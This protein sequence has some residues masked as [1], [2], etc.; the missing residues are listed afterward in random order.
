ML[1]VVIIF[2]CASLLLYLLLGGAD[3]GA[4]IIEM[5]TSAKNKSRTRRIAY[6]AIGPVWEANHMWLIIFIV[7]LFVGFPDIY[8]TM[9]TYLH[10]PLL[11]MLLGIILRGTAF[12]FRHYDAVKDN[13]QVVYNKI[14]VY[15]SFI[16]PLLL[17]MI[18]GAVIA[19]RINPDAD[20]FYM[21]YVSPWFN[22]FCFAVGL[23]TVALCGFLAAIYLVGEA[24][25]PYDEKRFIRKAGV[26]NLLTI[27]AGALVFITA[28]LE[29][30]H[31]W[32]WLFMDPVGRYM[33]IAALL[34]LAVLWYYLLKGRR[35][36]LLRLLAGFQVTMILLAIGYHNFPDFMILGNSEHLSLLQH[37]APKTTLKSLGWALLAGS[38]LILPFLGYLFYSF[39]RPSQEDIQSGVQ[40]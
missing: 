37:T 39:Q 27:A 26:I 15:S 17:G 25:S 4:G 40:Q 23:F 16:T 33:I 19:G 7:V 36:I 32:S 12:I 24:S 3:F 9:T 1:N 10:I 18:A 11:L 34:S 29:G 8:A 31:F 21:L 14:F 30:L 35:K 38:V 2:L 5:F 13:M 28:R 22:W 6:R 20:N